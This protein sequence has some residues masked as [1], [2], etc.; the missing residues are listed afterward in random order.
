MIDT[1]DNYAGP[2][3]EISGLS[4]YGD[5]THSIL[6]IV[7][8]MLA[9]ADIVTGSD[10][11][12]TLLGFAGNDTLIGNAGADFLDGGDDIDAASYATAGA[13]VFAG[14]EDAQYNTG[15]ASGDTYQAIENLIGSR[16][17][18][19]LYGNGGDNKLIGGKGNDVLV[20][21][22]GAD[23]F[24]GGAGVDAVSYDA[25]GSVKADLLKPSSNTGDAAGDVYISIENLDGSTF[26]DTLF[27]NNIGNVIRGNSYPNLASGAD[28]LHGRNG[29]D[30]LF[31]FDNSDT[32]FGDSGN[33]TIYGGAGNDRLIGGSGNDTIY[34]GAG[35]DRLIG[36]SG[37]DTFVFVS[38][39]GHD[40]I[41][42]YSANNA[43]DIDL[44]GVSGITSFADLVNNHLTTDGGTGFALI[45][46]GSNSILLS[47]ITVAEI[48]NGLAY[49]GSDF[50]F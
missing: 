36:G 39:F 38:G 24:N 23:T 32:L 30:K 45:V 17:S 46:D 42:G 29:N 15:D 31:G 16:F 3:Y 47:G 43:E 41:V 21:K 4:Y 12:D 11:A 37:N 28:A 10:G 27:G 19:I 35:N 1:N 6:Q 34:G 5:Y 7:A 2:N 40:V 49:S 26:S 13:G 20:G 25:S 50:I 48:G 14:L 33:D 18:D 22:A 44:S 9:G 8:D